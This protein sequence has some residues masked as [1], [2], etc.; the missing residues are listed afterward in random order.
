MS[1]YDRN[2]WEERWSQALSEHPDRAAQRPPNAHLTAELGDLLPGRALDA[3][4]GHGSETL[5]LA[6][7]G[8]Q[9]TAVDFAETAVAYAR[10]RAEA[11]G[12]EVAGRIDWLQADLASWAPR[13]DAYE[14]AVCL[15][16]HVAG[17]V[18]E[19]V[20]RMRQASLS[21]GPC[22]WSAIVRSSPPPERQRPRPGRRRCPWRPRAP[23]LIRAGGNWWSPRTVRVQ[24]RVPA[25]TP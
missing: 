8:W 4:C 5:W 3:G 20:E 2:F 18:E 11:M 21:A 10:S 6:A 12:P 23:P 17:S 9:L 15:Y 16:V 22:F 19:M 14:L 25:S 13:G 1:E 24:W 7:R